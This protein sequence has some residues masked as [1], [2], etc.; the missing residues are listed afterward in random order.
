MGSNPTATAIYQQERRPRGKSRGIGKPTTT[1]FRYRLHRSAIRCGFVAIPG[2]TVVLFA[3]RVQCPRC[4]IRVRR[5]ARGEP[6]LRCAHGDILRV[7][8]SV[9]AYVTNFGR[10]QLGDADRRGHE[11]P[12][13]PDPR[14]LQSVRDRDHARTAAVIDTAECKL[15]I[16]LWGDHSPARDCVTGHADAAGPRCWPR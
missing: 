4:E 11:H 5:C 8:R 14:R 16:P 7:P 15:P 2:S 1:Y 3:F 13:Q 9:T 12:R 6:D 10:E